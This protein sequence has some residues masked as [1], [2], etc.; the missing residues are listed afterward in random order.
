MTTFLD[1]IAGYIAALRC[2]LSCCSCSCCSSSSLVI[3]YPPPRPPRLS[4]C[5]AH[6]LRRPGAQVSGIFFSFEGEPRVRVAEP[7]LRYVAFSDHNVLGVGHVRCIRWTA[8]ENNK[9]WFARVGAWAWGFVLSAFVVVGHVVLFFVVHSTLS[10]YNSAAV[11]ST[12]FPP[13]LCSCVASCRE[14]ESTALPLFMLESRV[15]P[16]RFEELH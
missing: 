4:V 9:G 8:V 14:E 1:G 16:R 3:V 15:M 2:C 10:V 13:N 7:N 6:S 12:F 11:R 5:P